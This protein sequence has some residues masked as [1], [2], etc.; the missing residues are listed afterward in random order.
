[1]S[2]SLLV[3]PSIPFASA[4]SRG[5]GV[6]GKAFQVFG[7]PARWLEERATRSALANL[8]E[9]EWHD[10]GA[11]AR[12]LGCG[13]PEFEDAEDKAARKVALAAWSSDRRAAKA[14]AA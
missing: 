9:R 1:M 11:G 13:Y 14:R 5:Q 10:I 2:K 3:A 8:S 6:V 7:A 4:A 12:D